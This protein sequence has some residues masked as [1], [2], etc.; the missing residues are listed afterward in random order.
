MQGNILFDNIY[1]GHSLED[2]ESLKSQTYDVKHTIEKAEDEASNKA[3]ESEDPSEQSEF[4]KFKADPV[5][6]VKD[7]V[8]LFVTLAK[9]DPVEAVKLVP[10]V[11]GAA[12]IL[13]ITILFFLV[14]GIG[15]G[16]KSPAVQEQAKKAKDAASDAK[17]KASDAISSGAEKVATEANRRTTRSAAAADGSS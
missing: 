15:A 4:Q 13:V 3:A 11:A 14:G 8:N 2:A 16:A 12:G 10:E 17:D 5:S 6:Y 1:I 7:K 9:Q